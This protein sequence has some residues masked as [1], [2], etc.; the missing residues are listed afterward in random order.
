MTHFV[1][2]WSRY[3]RIRRRIRC[4]RYRYDASAPIKG[5]SR[6]RRF[7]YRRRLINYTM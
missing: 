5:A 6:F 4:P 1:F 7:R 2:I 3:R